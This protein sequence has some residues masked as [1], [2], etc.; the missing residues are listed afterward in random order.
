VPRVPQA[1]SRAVGRTVAGA[2]LLGW[3][4]AIAAAVGP[5]WGAADVPRLEFLFQVPG[6]ASARTFMNPLGLA[7]DPVRERLYVADT[8]H[9]QV[10]V[11]SSSGAILY[12]FK[13]WVTYYNGERVPGEPWR[14]L[15]WDRGTLLLA[16]RLSDRIDVVDAWGAIV[17]S[18][19]VTKLLGL[20]QR[21]TPGAMARDVAGNLY[22]LEHTTG[23]VLVL[24]RAR[25]LQRVI[26]PQ[27]PDSAKF[28]GVTDIAV[29]PDGTTYVLDHVEDTVVQVFDPTGKRLAGFGRHGAK[30]PDFHLPAAITLDGAGRL[31]I[32][33]AFSHEVKVYTTAGEFLTVFGRMGV[34]P[35]QFYFP[36]DV[37]VGAGVLY[38]L[39]R[40]GA[41]L[42][43]FRI[44]GP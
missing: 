23:Q 34:D 15:P 28:E 29:A 26:G 20:K 17:D 19:D 9:N 12:S 18:I 38:V 43:A 30:D 21:A 31:W 3:P 44:V 25:R 22:I 39:E 35:G 2:C 6:N 5:A 11:L 41:R 8:S 24:D 1:L 33:D 36:A 4:W 42:Q 16:D 7:F 37:A 14:L 13:H 27:G 40:A 32:A 10:T